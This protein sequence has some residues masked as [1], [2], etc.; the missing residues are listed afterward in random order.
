MTTLAATQQSVRRHWRLTS[1]IVVGLIAT[2]IIYVS[3]V[4]AAANDVETLLDDADALDIPAIARGDEAALASAQ[5]L[6]DESDSA[7]SSLSA[8]LGPTRVAAAS[9]GWVPW[10]GDQLQAPGILTDRAEADLNA[11][12]RLITS[13]DDLFALQDLVDSGALVDPAESTE[14]KDLLESLSDHAAGAETDM[15]QVKEQAERMDGM[16]LLWFLNSRVKRAQSLEGKLI[17]NSDVLVATP[18]AI[19]SA[20]VV[21]S[22]AEQLLTLLQDSTSTEN[23]VELVVILEVFKQDSEVAATAMAELDRALSVAM[24]QS[25][26]AMTTSELATSLIAVSELTAGLD[27]IGTNI[28]N[29]LEILRESGAP[30]LSNGDELQRALV[31]LDNEREALTEASQLARSALEVLSAQVL[32]GGI[33]FLDDDLAKAL[34]DRTEA[35]VDAGQLLSNGPELLRNLIAPDSSRK[36]LVLGQTSD[37]LRAA[38]GFTSSAWTL[39]FDDG[40]LTDT[41]F[42]PIIEF[43]NGSS[44]A[45]PAPHPLAYYMD[46]GALYLRDVG[47][48]PDFSTVGR[49]A[50]DLYRT[51][52][53]G[54]VDGV[55]AVNQ[56]AIVRLIEAIGGVEVDGQFISPGQTI[57]L[58][59]ARTDREGTGFLQVLFTS[60]LTSLRGDLSAGTQLDLLQAFS[61]ALEQKDLML[62]NVHESEQKVIEDA[63]WGGTFP[64]D[65]RDRLGIIDSNIGWTKSDRS[66]ARSVSYDLDLTNPAAPTAQLSLA[67]DHT[68]SSIGRDCSTHSSPPPEFVAYELSV[69]SCYWNYVRAFVAVGSEPTKTPEL[70]LPP[71][72]IPDVLSRQE[73]G[74]PTFS[75]NFDENGDHFAGLVA[76]EPGGQADFSIDYR[77]PN[78]IISQTEN[79]VRYELVLVAQPGA[80]LRQVSIEVSLPDGHTLSDSSHTPS[81]QG[82]ESLVFEIESRSDEVFWLETVSPA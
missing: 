48:A 54:E 4:L 5:S 52:Q 67:Y 53:P 37:E 21:K 13:A 39:T 51:N 69:N 35:L 42:I 63:G 28:S 34:V 82:A 2:A 78:T 59:E 12:R 14:L 31:V 60:L 19:S 74:S 17:A 68:G 30:L 49:T 79:G 75:H 7:T 66:I 56:W 8:R 32:E 26:L 11:A 22:S 45:P 27:V 81:T 71:N 50:A 73:P 77:L 43:D 58:I 70:P 15:E 72:S 61:E 44:D 62:F 47:W 41:Q 29:A 36:Y 57:D 25:N 10:A 64:L 6:L 16:S 9:L 18:P 40:S 38:G 65:Q 20:L 55:V 33:E 76:I 1:A 3:W 80:Q 46:A 24:P 23:L